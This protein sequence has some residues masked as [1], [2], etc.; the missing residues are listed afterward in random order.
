MAALYGSRR[1]CCCVCVL[2]QHLMFRGIGV[3]LLQHTTWKRGYAK[4]KKERRQIDSPC[5]C[6]NLSGYCKSAKYSLI[7]NYKS[8]AFF[9][10]IAF[11]MQLDI[12]YV[13]VH[14]KSYNNKSK[15][16]KTTYNFEWREYIPCRFL[17]CLYF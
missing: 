12:C 2:G 10:Y 8:L 11:I 14:N 1:T 6:F 3:D 16:S 9:R 5:A 17:I 4:G 7:P 13:Y 15:K